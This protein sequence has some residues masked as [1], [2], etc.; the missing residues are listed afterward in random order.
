MDND[1]DNL[2]I[3]VSSHREKIIIL[4]TNVRLR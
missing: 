1:E 3:Q 2:K 4:Y